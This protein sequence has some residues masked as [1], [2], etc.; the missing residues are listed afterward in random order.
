MCFSAEADVVGGLF[1]GVVGLDA[2]RHVEHKSERPLAALPLLFGAHQITE[3]FVWWGLED[4][5]P[6]SVGEAAA[7]AY[8][9]FAFA[10]LPVLVPV[11]VR[12]VE[13]EVRRRGLQKAWV[14][15]G[16]AVAIVYLVVTTGRTLTA[17]VDGNHILYL[18]AL[19]DSGTFGA[20][21]IFATCAPLFSSSHR[22]IVA[23]G[24]VN[25]AAVAVLLTIESNG[26]TSLWCAWAA[27]SSVAIA[28]H[29]RFAH[30][31]Q[32]RHARLPGRVA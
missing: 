11:A 23:F 17:E 24:L 6:W 8:L 26:K 25:L 4:R 5:V 30:G 31:S 1:A 32:T 29:L 9:A 13:P 14:G 18:T 16:I 15:L 2:L 21:Y 12:A 3:A 19:S 28:A 22:R 7:W 20:F 27:M 10:L